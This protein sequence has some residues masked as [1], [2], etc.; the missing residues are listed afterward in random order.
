MNHLEDL[1]IKYGNPYFIKADNGPEFRIDCREK[2]GAF[3]ANLINSPGYY[4]QFNGA[5]ERLHRTLRGM[6]QSSLNI[7]IFSD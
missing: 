7:K 2:Q 1:V 6:S 5:H 3:T 4:G